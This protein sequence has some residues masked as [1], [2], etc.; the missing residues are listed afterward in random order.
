M[1]EKLKQLVALLII[2][3]EN[4]QVIWNKASGDYQF[5]LILDSGIA[6]TISYYEGDINDGENY[7]IAVFNSKGDVV[8]RYYCYVNDEHWSLLSKFHRVASDTYYNVDETFEELLN[9][10]N[11]E[12]VIGTVSEEGDDLPF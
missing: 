8:H 12:D 11:S 2:K 3:T 9:S 7:H 6:V 4:K 1:N 10:V 5:K